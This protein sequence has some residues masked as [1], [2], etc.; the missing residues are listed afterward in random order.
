MEGLAEHRSSRPPG[1]PSVQ[2][3]I[4]GSRIRGAA[5]QSDAAPSI[6]TFTEPH[7]RTHF[8]GRRGHADNS[9][10]R[11]DR[12][13]REVHPRAVRAR[14]RGLRVG[15]LPGQRAA[16]RVRRRAGGA[17]GGREGAVGR[18]AP[19]LVAAARAR[20]AAVPGRA[21]PRRRHGALG[22]PG[23]RAVG[24]ADR[25]AGR[26]RQRP[27][28]ERRAA[29][30]PRRRRSRRRHPG[31]GGARR[32]GRAGGAAGLGG[33][34]R[35]RGG[36]RGPAARGAR[37]PQRRQALLVRA[38]HGRRQDGRGARLRRG[39]AHRRHADPHPPPQP[40][41]PVPRRAARPRLRRSGSR[42]RSCAARTAPTGR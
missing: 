41:R 7:G 32:R 22:A 29:G 28:R 21:A 8:S 26:V 39:L 36:R 14:R 11:R 38:R 3:R 37:G 1:D 2:A 10:R 16:A 9:L 6:V 24:H 34:R 5:Q 42:R 35:G 40:R 12:A 23:R 30:R 27:L 33:R 4:S 15:A 25:A 13:R 19:A 17:G 31:R 18:L 20:P